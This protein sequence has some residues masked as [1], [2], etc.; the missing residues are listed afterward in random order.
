MSLSIVN[1]TWKRTNNVGRPAS[2]LVVHHEAFSVCAW[3]CARDC[4]RVRGCARVN[5]RARDCVRARACACVCVRARDCVRV[6]ACACVCVR[7]RMWCEHDHNHDCV[8]TRVNM[9]TTHSGHTAQHYTMHTPNTPGR[10]V[11]SAVHGQVSNTPGTIS[12]GEDVTPASCCLGDCYADRPPSTVAGGYRRGGGVCRQL[13]IKAAIQE[14]RVCTEYNYGAVCCFVGSP[15]TFDAIRALVQQ[16][17][18]HDCVTG[19][20]RR[21]S[22]PTE[23]AACSAALEHERP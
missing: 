12:L 1:G 10:T 5:V 3:V 13:P 2:D 23:L 22:A 14:A 18:C 8:C 11:G 20:H 4:V 7:V 19:R 17:E 21:C 9:D 15:Q 6:R 16:I